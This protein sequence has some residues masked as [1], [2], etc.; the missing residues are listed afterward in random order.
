MRLKV[1]INAV[2]GNL[3]Y[4]DWTCPVTRLIRTLASC[5]RPNIDQRAR[6]RGEFSQTT[7]SM[8][9]QMLSGP[10]MSLAVS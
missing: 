1:L 8:K 9:S 7:R 6:R 5:F 10:P 3:K 2:T 4:R